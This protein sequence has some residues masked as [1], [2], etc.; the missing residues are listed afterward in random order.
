MRTTG[1]LE[2][3]WMVAKSTSRGIWFIPF[4]KVVQ[5]SF[6]WCRIS[7]PSTVG[8]KNWWIT[9]FSSMIYKYTGY[10]SIMMICHSDVE[11]P[12]GSTVFCHVWIWRCTT[13]LLQYSDL[14]YYP[15]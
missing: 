14:T 7:Q 1:T 12:E 9:P 6:W 3:T 8:M 5:P 15:K 2:F 13:I 11:L 4:V 10:L